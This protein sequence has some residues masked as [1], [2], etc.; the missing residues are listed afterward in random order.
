MPHTYTND[1]VTF[2]EDTG[3]GP[4]VVL[5]HG[6]AGP[7]NGQIYTD[8][9]IPMG[10]QTDEWIAAVGSYIR[11]AFGNRAS[12]ISAADVGRVRRA[13]AT[14]TTS[15][16]AAELDASLPRQ[17]V[18]DSGWKFAASHN[19]AIASYAVTIQP[20]TSGIR[21]Q[22][23]MWLQ[24]ELPQPVM[25]TELQFESGAV[26]IVEDPIVPGAPPRSGAG[27]GSAAPVGVGYPRG[28]QVQVSLDGA[29]WS[30]PIAEGAGAGSATAITF[31]PVGAKFV[32]LT[33]TQPVAD[34]PP[35]AIQRLR[36]Y[37]VK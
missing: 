30:T 35:L 3:E 17:I 28:Y 33:Q 37:E 24:V 19:P 26:A 27:R 31:A 5:I 16:T 7:V 18:F 15:W 9:M 8:V 36:L 34:A 1:I 29:N 23:G 13:T 25:L 10:Q 4:V 6:M 32:R 20:W 21:Q 22:P 14:R 12:L 11:N 2:Y